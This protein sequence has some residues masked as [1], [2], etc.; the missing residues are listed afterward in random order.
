VA[1]LLRGL[2][3]QAFQIPS[4]SMLPTLQIGDYLLINQLR[5][6]IRLPIGGWLLWF[7]EPQTGDVVVFSDPRDSSQDFVKR[8]IAVGGETVEIRN[9]RVYVDGVERDDPGPY[10]VHA[11][12]DVQSLAQRDNFGPARVP[13]GQ[14][15]VLGDNRDQSVDSRYWG[16][17]PVGDVQGKA[18]M[19]YWSVDADDGWV[20]WERLGALV[21]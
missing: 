12:S 3:L 2:V 18:F 20:R 9:K 1:L 19:V 5:Y 11:P 8:V 16:F 21:R 7:S 15:F 13:P 10:F 4:G 17:V 6:G 14:L